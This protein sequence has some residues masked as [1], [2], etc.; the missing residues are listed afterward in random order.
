MFLVLLFISGKAFSQGVIY[1][2]V[3][4]EGTYVE[5]SKKDRWEHQDQ[6]DGLNLIFYDSARAK[7]YRLFYRK[8]GRI[9][10]GS[11]TF[12]QEG[13]LMILQYYSDGLYNGY[14]YKWNDKGVLVTKELYRDG[15]LIK[16][17]HYKN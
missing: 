2:V 10:G 14:T 4:S 13:M 1:G 5:S 6:I 9:S 8:N 11:K 15:D 3:K 7:I 12:N 17:W 16:I